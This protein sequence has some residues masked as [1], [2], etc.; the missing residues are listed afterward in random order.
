MKEQCLKENQEQ[1]QKFSTQYIT[2]YPTTQHSHNYNQGQELLGLAKGQQV[3]QEP[4]GS[5]DGQQ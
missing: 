5:G 2:R 4:V 1:I 3:S